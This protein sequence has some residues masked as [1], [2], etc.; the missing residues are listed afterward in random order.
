MARFSSDFGPLGERFLFRC[1][2]FPIRVR[3]RFGSGED[4]V[5][6]Y[7]GMKRTTIVLPDDLDVVV[8][9]E[10]KRA[11]ASVSEL[12]RRALASYV[13]F[14]QSAPR[15][16]SF[17]ALGRSGQRHTARDVESILKQ[18]WDRVRRR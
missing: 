2:A 5:C 10:A 12:V 13:G 15:K 11:G 1:A 18:E 4:F 3:A 8:K 17:A 16:L 14:N 6:Q 7:E 9:R